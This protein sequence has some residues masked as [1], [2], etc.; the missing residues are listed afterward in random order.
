MSVF[1]ILSCGE[2]DNNNVEEQD[3]FEG[4]CSPDPVFGPNV[5]N[6]DQSAGAIVVDNIFTPN[7]DGYNDLFGIENIELYENHTV[8]IY[9]IEDNVVF[10]SN[11]YGNE[12]NYFPTGQQGENGVTETPDGTYKYKVVIENEETFRESG[13]FC[14]FTQFMD[15]EQNFSE[16]NPLDQGFDPII[17][18]L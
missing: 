17:S 6:L 8:T 7:G 9:D 2:D 3:V 1:T 15:V 10:E 5:D 13:T 11:N 16:C 18:G 14:L 4:C 12:N